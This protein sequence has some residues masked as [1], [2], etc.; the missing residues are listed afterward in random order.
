MANSIPTAGKY[1]LVHNAR[2]AKTIETARQNLA[3][4]ANVPALSSG[5]GAPS[6]TPGKVGD[7]YVDTTAGKLYFAKAATASSDWVL[8][9]S[10]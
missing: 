10:A 3:A 6:S 2:E 1:P 9:T 7:L 5:A 8:V 4:S